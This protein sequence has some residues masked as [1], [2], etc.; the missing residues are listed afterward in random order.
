MKIFIEFFKF[1]NGHQSFFSFFILV[2][3]LLKRSSDDEPVEISPAASCA[4][5]NY[6]MYA[7]ET[8]GV[9]RILP[10]DMIFE[11]RMDNDTCILTMFPNTNDEHEAPLIDC[12][13]SNPTDFVNGMEEDPGMFFEIFN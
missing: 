12:D 11:A 4:L 6:D 9:N 3:I 1:Q 2:N 10:D 5:Y 13:C 7:A 8:D